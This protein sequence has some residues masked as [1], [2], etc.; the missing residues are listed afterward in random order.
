MTPPDALSE[1]LRRF[2]DWH[3]GATMLDGESDR[4]I[5]RALVE[6]ATTSRRW[7]TRKG[8][9]IDHRCDLCDALRALDSALAGETKKEGEK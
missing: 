5:L 8:H 9:G 3:D 1:W 4:V 6:V 7:K 2:T